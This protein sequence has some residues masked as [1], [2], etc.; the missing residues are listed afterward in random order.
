MNK[1]SA[2]LT[3]REFLQVPVGFAMGLLASDENSSSD[4]S[5]NQVVE[6]VAQITGVVSGYALS[7]AVEEIIFPTHTPQEHEAIQITRIMFRLQGMV[8]GWSL[9]RAVGSEL[10]K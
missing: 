4:E 10:R 9:G 7:R 6:N 2:M 5:A 8:M 3:R 1:E